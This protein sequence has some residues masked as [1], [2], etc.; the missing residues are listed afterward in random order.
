MAD[1][2]EKMEAVRQWCKSHFPK[3]PKELAYRGQIIRNML[4]KWGH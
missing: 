3:L 1:G 2:H 4:Y